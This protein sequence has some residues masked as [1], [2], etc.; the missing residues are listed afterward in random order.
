[1]ICPSKFE[2]YSGFVHSSVIKVTQG[3]SRILK[4]YYYKTQIS[5]IYFPTHI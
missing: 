3:S 4:E 2:L 1:M 5:L